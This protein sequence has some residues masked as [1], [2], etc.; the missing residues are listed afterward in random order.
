MNFSHFGRIC[1][2]YLV[3]FVTSNPAQD[4]LTQRNDNFRTGQIS[5]PGL[6]Q[7]AVKTFQLLASLAVDAPILSQPL[8]VQNQLFK[9]LQLSV[10]WVA[11]ANNTIYAFNS[12]APFQGLCSF[13]LGDPKKYLSGEDHQFTYLQPGA[14]GIIGIESTPVI[15]RNSNTMFVSYRRN[16]PAPDGQQHLAAID[17]TSCSV[18]QDV[19]VPGDPD[20]QRLHRNRASLLMDNGVIYVAFAGIV[21]SNA[22]RT[23]AY[24]KPWHGWIHAF[25]A[26][27][28]GHLDSYQTTHDSPNPT[29]DVTKDGQYWGGGIWQASTGLA[30]DGNGNI[31]FASGNNNP[32]GKIVPDAQN[33]ASSVVRLTVSRQSNPDRVTMTPTDWFTPYS[34]FWQDDQDIDL[35]SAGVMLIPDTNYLALA[36]KEGVLYLLD[37]NNM[38]KFDNQPT[39]FCPELAS[40]SSG[41]RAVPDDP[42][43]DHVT[44]KVITGTN[45]YFAAETPPRPLGTCGDVWM[46][47]PHVH[48]TPSFASFGAAKMLYVWPEKDH[49]QSFR[50]LGNKL[51][52]N[53][54]FATN[55]FGQQALAPPVKNQSRQEFMY[56]NGVGMP[57]AMLSIAIDSTKPD[58][59]VLFASVKTCYDSGPKWVECSTQLCGNIDKLACFHQNR[60]NLR[61]FDPI[62][63][64]ELWNDQV[65]T[66]LGIQNNYNFAKFVS[67]TIANSRV[68][69][70]TASNTVL[71]YGNQPGPQSEWRFCEKCNSL[72]FD[73]SP[74]KGRCPAGGSHQ[75]AGINFLLGHDVALDGL[76][77]DKQQGDWRFCTKCNSLFFNGYPA[78]GVCPAGGA[79]VAAGYVFV[80]PHDASTQGQTSWRFCQK[81]QVMFYDGSPA[82]GRCA[83]G[84][85]HEAAGYGF[86]L[87]QMPAGTQADWRFCTKC[88]GLYFDGSPDKGHC[89][90]GGAHTAAGFVFDLP[91]DGNTNG[92]ADWRFCHKC[93]GMFFDGSSAKGICPA[94]GAHEAIGYIFILPHDTTGPGQS[95]WRFCN[96]CNIMFFAGYPDKGRCPAGGAHQAAGYVFLLNHH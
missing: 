50:W 10:L 2:A 55:L 34:K 84:G 93:N 42:A 75:Q 12:E 39:V 29:G 81:C 70:A 56:G 73:G 5:Q 89:P 32:G 27:T 86:V 57:G 24:G 36:G 21:E 61:A 48:G 91:H 26:K 13:H 96:K 19:I 64:K 88:K 77:L 85:A 30:A 14:P 78:K 92:Q 22:G 72:Y 71:I 83:K 23:D 47:W 16:D 25:D 4:I 69:L 38:G 63:L 46:N 31:Y 79:H 65:S 74:N 6:D 1:L 52:P 53:P 8:V 45:R 95:S 7:N 37:R 82:K 49:L 94:G 54:I 20:W 28:L 80:L 35:G 3:L 44:Q 51:D 60:G 62:T 18:R 67:P 66:R 9:N 40:A 76:P 43:R 90:A 41:S 15:D 33:L 59:G 58:A 11:T 87:P 68:Y 17:I